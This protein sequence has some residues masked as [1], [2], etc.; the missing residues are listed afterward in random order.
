MRCWIE[1]GG[2]WSVVGSWVGSHHEMVRRQ[3]TRLSDLAWCDW[4]GIFKERPTPQ[5]AMDD[6][7]REREH[8]DAKEE[9]VIS[10]SG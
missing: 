9:K 2:R 8:R 4:R 6:V 5:R 7:D 3:A 1:G 10:E